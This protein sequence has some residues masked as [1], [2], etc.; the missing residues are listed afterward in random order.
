MQHKGYDFAGYVTKNDILCTDGVVIKQDAF[1]NAH[2]KKV[3]LVWNH[4]YTKP[5]NILGYVMLHKAPLGTYGYGFF[6]ESDQAKSA[7]EMV[8]HGDIVSMSIGAR[9]IKRDGS[10]VIHGDIYEVSLVLAGANPGAMIDSIM[11]HSSESG[12]TGIIYTGTLLHSEDDINM[13]EEEE[14]MG[15]TLEDIK[16]LNEDELNEFLDQLSNEELKALAEDLG[17][18]VDEEEYEEDNNDEEDEENNNDPEEGY[19]VKHNIF[20][21]TEVTQEVGMSKEEQALLLQSAINGK[22]DSFKELLHAAAYDE[23]KQVGGTDFGIT[24]IEYLFPETHNLQSTP[25]MIMDRNTAFREIINGVAKVPFSKIRTRYFD[26]DIEDE[27]QR[28]K[29]YVKGTRKVDE[30][31]KL[32]R[33]ET[34]PTTIYKKQKL[35]RDDIIEITDFDVVSALRAEMRTLLEIELARCILMGDGRETSSEHKINEEKIR[36]IIKDDEVYTIKAEYDSA[37]KFIEAVIKAMPEYEGSGSPTLFIDP[38]LLADVKLLKG[39][40]GR[41][42]NGHI[43]TDAEIA[44]QT[45]VAKVVPTTFLKDK[46]YAV[47]VNLNDYKVG[48]TKG[49]QLTSF[50]DF[51][52]DFNRHKYLIETRLSGALGTPKSAIFFR[53]KGTSLPVG[54]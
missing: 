44:L 2:G 43:A 21:G 5:D 53:K 48:S 19:S 38:V 3:P 8:K 23:T 45:G 14:N 51:D 41:W 27:K 22:V 13:E 34:S 17:L 11:S 26:I 18:E 32:L 12:E 16:N 7:K 49:G 28:A 24:N 20:N 15:F 9:Q 39:T 1:T 40:D 35:D 52:I 4:D 54:E 37:D 25:P 30:V 50:E 31:I 42:L 36:P 33:R 47:A 29:G 6:N 46:G 10:N